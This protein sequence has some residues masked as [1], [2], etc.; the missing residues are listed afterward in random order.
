MLCACAIVRL[1]VWAQL[2]LHVVATET[3]A[4]HVCVRA[5]FLSAF[6]PL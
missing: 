4:A 3:V 6:P 5:T 1:C 2:V